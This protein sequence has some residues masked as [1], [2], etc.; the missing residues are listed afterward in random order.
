MDG[1]P[2]HAAL[3]SGGRFRQSVRVLTDPPGLDTLTWPLDPDVV[4]LNHGSFGATPRAGLQIQARLR[5]EMNGAPVRW[6]NAL[7]ERLPQARAR[8]AAWLGTPPELTAFVPNATA[9]AS[10]VFRSLRLSPGDEVLVTDHGY[11]AVT[12]GAARMAMRAGAELRTVSLPLTADAGEVVERVTAGLTERTRLLVIDHATSPTALELPAAELC[13]RARERG[14][15]TL[16]DG[17]HTPG[18]LAR[19]WVAEADVWVG[20]LH[21]WALCPRPAAV[22]VARP[23]IADELDPTIDSWGAGKPYPHRFDVQGTNDV[24]ALLAAPEVLDLVEHEVGWDATRAW[25]AQLLDQGHAVVCAALADAFG[26][27]CDPHE[28]RPLPQM[29]LVRIP[30]QP[31]DETGVARVRHLAGPGYEVAVTSFGG[32]TYVRLSAHL[33]NRLLDY[34]RFAAEVVPILARKGQDAHVGPLARM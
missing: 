34:Q 27:D 9:G 12:M 25:S 13:R 15:L 16:V 2:C 7:P 32:S 22:I 23:E 26:E 8:I 17:A 4:H 28:Q 29:R 24:T 10:A 31:G 3:Y 20:N 5:D 14:V 18:M 6:F 21:K 30:G 33:H 11:G 1:S 19:P